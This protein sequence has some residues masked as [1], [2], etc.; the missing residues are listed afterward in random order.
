MQLRAV[1]SVLENTT[2]VDILST[3]SV[4]VLDNQKATI[5][6]GKDVPQETGQY[7]TTGTTSTVTPFTTI[8]NKPV[9]LK[10]DVTPQINLGTAVR[11]KI[12]LKNDTLQN[13][14]NPGLTPIINT[15]KIANSVI[16]NS[17]DVLVLGGLI[18]HS[19]VE[20]INKVPILGDVPILGNLF[21]QKSRKVE[22][23]NLVVFIK[24]VI[25]HNSDDGTLITHMK[26]NDIRQ[27][28]INFADEMRKIGKKPLNTILPPWKN[29]TSLPSPFES[30]SK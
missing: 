11:L 15:S 25:L 9:T 13:P 12:S 18:S 16:I 10:L 23:K 29:K 27:T 28:E 21:T 1:L 22:K 24:P 4:V 30:S 2:G 6:V 7:A 20:N 17:Q 19:T 5:E 26:Y 14:D 3:P 8:V